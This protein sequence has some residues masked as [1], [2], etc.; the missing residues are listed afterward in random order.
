MICPNAARDE[1]KK[2]LGN[3][4]GTAWKSA[5]F[6]LECVLSLWRMRTSCRE[7]SAPNAARLAASHRLTLQVL[8]EILTLLAILL[9]I[10]QK[11]TGVDVFPETALQAKAPMEAAASIMADTLHSR[12]ILLKNPSTSLP[13]RLWHSMLHAEIG[14]TKFSRLI[15]KI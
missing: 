15:S 4:D 2:P 13:A 12:W 8:K 5:T 1:G 11:S 14:R 3:P 7:Q 9:D 6:M 10:R